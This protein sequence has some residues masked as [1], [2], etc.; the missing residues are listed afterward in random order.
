MNAPA[1][2]VTFFMLAAIWWLYAWLY[3]DYRTDLLRHR[4]FSARDKLFLAASEGKIRFDDPAYQMTRTTLNGGLRFAHQLTLSKFLLIYFLQRKHYPK[5]G[6]EYHA[7]LSESM[8]SL[9]HEQK[10]LILSVYLDFHLAIMSH[11]VHVSFFPLAWLT[12]LLVNLHLL[13]RKTSKGTN[14]NFEPIDAHAFNL[15]VCP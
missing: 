2:I 8:R 3:I 4:L 10:K 14:K 12:K 5:A 9:S 13:N 7:M 11:I 15:G 6:E 1:I